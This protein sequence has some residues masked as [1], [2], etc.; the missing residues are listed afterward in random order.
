MAMVTAFKFDDELAVG[1]ASGQP[2][3]RHRGLR[4]TINHPDFFDRRNPGADQAGHL[5]LQRVWYPETQPALGGF[6]DRFDD[7]VRSMTKDRGPPGP[8]VIDI[9]VSFDIPH[10]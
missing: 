6:A 8:N 4:T 10:V 9:L 2:N 1:C 3:T 5:D 7:D